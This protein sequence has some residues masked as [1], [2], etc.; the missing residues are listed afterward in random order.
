MKVV[1]FAT[2]SGMFA[3]VYILLGHSNLRDPPYGTV[4]L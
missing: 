2:Q 3:N 1:L 4:K